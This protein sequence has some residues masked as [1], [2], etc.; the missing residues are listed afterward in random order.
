MAKAKVKGK[1]VVDSC[2][3]PCDIGVYKPSLYLDLEGKDVAQIKGLTVGEEV[4]VL[5]IGKVR[6]LE[7]RERTSDYGPDKG[8]TKTTGSISVEE[9]EVQILEEEDNEYVK[10]A[11]D[12]S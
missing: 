12:E 7:Q 9:Y 11:E 10:M 1:K 8:K 5:V 3:A 4:Q 2:C 6:S